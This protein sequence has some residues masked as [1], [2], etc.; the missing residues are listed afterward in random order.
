MTPFR[1]RLQ[2]NPPIRNAITGWGCLP[3]PGGLCLEPDANL[4][5]A[6]GGEMYQAIGESLSIQGDNKESGGAFLQA[7]EAILA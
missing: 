1:R 7:A 2:L 3:A 4:R 6:L 5:S